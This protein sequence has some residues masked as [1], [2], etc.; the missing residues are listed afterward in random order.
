MNKPSEMTRNKI[1]IIAVIVIIVIVTGIV[2]TKH[3]KDSSTNVI[4]PS[5]EPVFVKETSVLTT[6]D[7][8][9]H[10]ANIDNLQDRPFEIN[11]LV[12]TKVI[13][14]KVFIVSTDSKNVLMLYVFSPD[15]KLS[16][17]VGAKINLKGIL[18]KAVSADQIKQQLGLSQ[19]DAQDLTNHLIYATTTK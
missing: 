3:G 9:Y 10:T 6:F 13:S 4:K 8:I 16:P 7:G 18:H 15:I 2:V 19:K 1:I 5:T 14:D 11:G 12:I 17:K